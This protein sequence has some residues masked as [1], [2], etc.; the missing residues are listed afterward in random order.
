MVGANLA[1]RLLPD[2]VRERLKE[3]HRRRQFRR[4]L[5]AF[6]RRSSGG[7]KLEGALLNELVQYWGNEGW[8][9]H[10]DFL[11]ASIQHALVADGPVLECGS[12][13]STI[14]VGA[15]AQ[16]RGLALTS[17]EH[18]A[19]WASRV[20]QE[21]DHAGLGSIALITAP[22]VDMGEFAWYHVPAADLPERISLVLCDGPPGDTK[23]GRYG[24]LPVVRDRLL[25]GSVILLDDV[26]REDERRIATRWAAELGASLAI[27]DCDKPFAKLTLPHVF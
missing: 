1:K 9:A 22:L 13:L 12:G 5:R 23:G 15:V 19:E 8:S 6:I 11:A 21:L 17:L 4:A 26:A 2:R 20:Q 14:L 10:S 27:Q 18:T 16:P 7:T 24:L 3:L 25:P